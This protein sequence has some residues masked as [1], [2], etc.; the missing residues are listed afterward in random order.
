M[1]T[2][3]CTT[4][5]NFSELKYLNVNKNKIIMKI[6]LTFQVVIYFKK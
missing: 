4:L 2:T 6:F 3:Q 1:R 5:K